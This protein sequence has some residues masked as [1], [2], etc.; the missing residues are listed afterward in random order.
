MPNATMASAAVYQSTMVI[1]TPA[2]VQNA[3]STPTVRVTKHVCAVNA[4][5]R[6]RVL[7]AKTPYAT[8][9]TTF[10]CAGVQMVPLVAPLY[11]ALQCQ[12]RCTE[13]LFE[14]SLLICVILLQKLLLRILA[15]RHHV[16]QTLNVAKSISRPSVLV[17]PVTL[18]LR[19]HADPSAPLMLSVHPHRRV[20][21]NVV[22][23]HVQA[24]AASAP[25]VPWLITVLSVLAPLVLQEIRLCVASLKVSR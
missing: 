11:D 17:Y 1:P 24:L 6:A 15:N 5:I 2:V 8:S 22:V 13:I 9:S 4:S 18:E 19:Q 23:I 14:L 7:V 20:L 16:V 3:C 25:I 12:V 21:I 10:P